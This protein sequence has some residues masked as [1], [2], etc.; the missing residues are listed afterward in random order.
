MSAEEMALPAV[1]PVSHPVTLRRVIRSE[2]TKM[3]SLR[4]TW[5]VLIAITLFLVGLS[6]VFGATYASDVRDGSTVASDA[7]AVDAAFRAFHLGGL[8]VVILGMLQMTAEYSSGSIA[9]SLVAVPRRLQFLAGKGLA[10]VVVVSAAM[11]VASLGSFVVSQ[12]LAGDH[13]VGFGATGA[14]RAMVAAPLSVVALS[15]VGLGLATAIR[16]TAGTLSVYVTLML[17]TPAL[18]ALAVPRAVGDV[19]L[20]FHPDLVSEAI[21]LV[22]RA[23]VDRDLLSPLVAFSVLVL[24]CV[25]SLGAGA[26]ALVRRDA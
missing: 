8:I 20:P 26:L 22:N 18:L 7:S 13:G 2:L 10:L 14:V 16:H 15:L 24:Y 21:Y 12:V 5:V 1:G 19:V 23:T 3:C 4:S 17:A 6:A 25:V 11:A 9:V